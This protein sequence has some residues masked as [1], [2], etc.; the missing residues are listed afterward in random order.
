MWSNSLPSSENI[1][2]IITRIHPRI[3][4]AKCKTAR[5]VAPLTPFPL[6]D[7]SSPASP[8]SISQFLLSQVNIDL[9]LLLLLLLL[10]DVFRLRTKRAGQGRQ[11]RAPTAMRFPGLVF[12]FSSLSNP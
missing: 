4:S 1:K 11:H 3:Q 7:W 5:L 9:L 8:V 10:F 6:P 12:G 2:I